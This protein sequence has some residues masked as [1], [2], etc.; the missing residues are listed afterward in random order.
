[1]SA[2]ETRTFRADDLETVLGTVR[3]E[4]G[5]DAIV[6]RQR[7]GIVGGI[8]GFFGKRCVEVD[9]EC[10]PS[11]AP[12]RKTMAMPARAVTDAY[13]SLPTPGD[14]DELAFDDAF[15]NLG[16][17]DGGDLFKS[18]IGDTSVFAST[19]AE[20]IEREPA[21]E[22]A[23]APVAE[24]VFVP[25]EAPAVDAPRELELRA[26]GPV[27]QAIVPAPA[28][29][30]AVPSAPAALP[31]SNA[32]SVTLALRDAGIDLRLAES[33]VAEADSQ[34]RLFDPAEPFENQIR[35]ALASRIETRRLTGRFRRRVIALV[36]APGSGKTSTAARMCAAHV[37]AGRRVVALSLE[38]VRGAVELA[39][40]TEGIGVE[41][42]SADH[43]GLIDFAL[44]RVARAD[45]VIV[46]TPGV[47][48]ADE[49]GWARIAMLMAP[50]MVHETHLLLPATLDAGGV[51]SR[52]GAV[53]EKL[54]VDRL[55]L[56]HAACGGPGP[57]V[58]ASLRS[59]IPISASATADRLV[60]AD[61][62]ALAAA[63]L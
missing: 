35:Q 8:G 47:R 63:I 44:A 12:A 22:P 30:L 43:P 2:L 17:D 21:D 25:L 39:Q 13:T 46:D 11:E 19:L 7:E 52:L 23:T 58:S 18:L 28:P 33:I 48:T 50:L 32:A 5:P 36:G 42:I 59:G 49:D 9:V 61:A 34:L 15:D 27:E 41:L 38:P 31:Y 10:P 60:P 53:S 37:A 55:L 4:F 14:D 29:L 57:V 54:R 16:D 51:G 20:A 45:V 62:Y 26:P 24:P 6:V 40:A 1:M 56:T 3:E